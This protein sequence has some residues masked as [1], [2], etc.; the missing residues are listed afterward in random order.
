MPGPCSC[1]T[2]APT[3]VQGM[4]VL[5]GN[6]LDEQYATRVSRIALVIPTEETR[7]QISTGL[8]VD[9]VKREK[10]LCASGLHSVLSAYQLLTREEGLSK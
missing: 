8:S 7:E 6:E 4:Y 10:S 9:H 1:W 2:P 3:H 5:T